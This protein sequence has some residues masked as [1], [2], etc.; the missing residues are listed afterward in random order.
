MEWQLAK[1]P[2]NRFILPAISLAVLGA[3]LILLRGITY[4]PG[5]EADSVGYVLAAK[6]FAAGNGFVFSED[7][8]LTQWPPL[9]PT[10]LSAAPFFGFDP[11]GWAGLLNAILFG[12][13][14]FI[15]SW[16][17]QRHLKETFLVFWATLA[18]L[19]S[20][21]LTAQAS[22]VMSDFAFIL[23]TLVSLIQIEKFLSSRDNSPLVCAAIFTGLACL[24]R[25]IG[26]TLV[27]TGILLLLFTRET[28][29]AKTKHVATYTFIAV[30][31]AGVWLLR[32][33]L[34]SGF[35]VGQRN[36]SDFSLLDVLYMVAAV[37]TSW[38]VPGLSASATYPM[39]AGILTLA[40]S[41]ALICA[42]FI[43]LRDPETKLDR[44]LAIIIFGTFAVIYVTLLVAAAISVAFNAIDYDDR[45]LSPIYIPLVFVGALTVDRWLPSTRRQ[46]CARIG[47]V[48]MGLFLWLAYLAV[49][50]ISNIHF[51]VHHGTGIYTSKRWRGSDLMRAI[52][53][54]LTDL[55]DNRVYSNDRFA[56]YIH[57]GLYP[58]HF[59][60]S[61]SSLPG[62]LREMRRTSFI[63]GD[64][65]LIWWYQPNIPTDYGITELEE[66]Y[67]PDARRVLEVSDGVIYRVNFRERLARDIQKAGEP[68]IRSIFD[69]YFD[70]A[71]LIYMKESCTQ[72]EKTSRL[73]L[74]VVPVDVSDLPESRKKF[75][76]DNLDFSFDM[77]G[78]NVGGGRCLA[79]VFLPEYPIA[80]IF[81]GRTIPAPGGGQSRAWEG[82]FDVME[83][84]E[85]PNARM[86]R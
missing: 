81:T 75:G 56:V 11:V 16:W 77:Y 57:T 67:L 4:G 73:F 53:Q 72:K 22:R 12:M 52:R 2:N 10:L 38:V 1:R 21:C 82:S 7:V 62:P 60:R 28:L 71:S 66:R 51:S 46:R 41:T 86:D 50:N 18:I 59:S 36:P 76:F 34:L 63:A 78:G 80:K 15:A 40:I 39:L 35:V 37:L 29:L 64:I 79:Q 83:K 6:N 26:V 20:P 54:R 58:A 17:L 47:L 8:I 24:T 32:N 30:I 45:M 31:P 69:V 42:S 84:A 9:F 74:H 19:L 44:K 33:S 14:V 23:F 5:M 68:I 61:R 85:N 55:P 3:L 13:A 43:V 27:C 70:K 49:I 65:Y 25:Y 48:S